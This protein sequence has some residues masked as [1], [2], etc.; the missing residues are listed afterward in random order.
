[1]EDRIQRFY[2]E[3]AREFDTGGPT[4]YFRRALLSLISK[5]IPETA[6]ILDI[7]CATGWLL[8]TL[9]NGRRT[10]V[11]V[12]N[13]EGMAAHASGF[14]MIRA[15]ARDFSTEQ[16]FDT[17][18]ISNLLHHFH[19]KDLENMM[20][21]ALKALGERGTIFIVTPNILSSLIFRYIYRRVAKSYGPRLKNIFYAQRNV[22]RILQ[23]NNINTSKRFFYAFPLLISLGVKQVEK[24]EMYSFPFSGYILFEGVKKGG[25][26]ESALQIHGANRDS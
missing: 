26:Q 5:R 8:K 3:D 4:L 12:D 9:D 21:N 15:D 10:L 24:F 25:G 23:E 14:N 17:I 1:M 22:K 2:D 11:G 18:V 6:S 7:G 19:G 20:I 16:R 13:S